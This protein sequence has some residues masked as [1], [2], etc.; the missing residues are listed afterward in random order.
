MDLYSKMSM[1]S[2]GKSGN[3][4]LLDQKIQAL[5]RL[6]NIIKGHHVTNISPL[7][8]FSELHGIVV[9]ITRPDRI[10][11]VEISYQCDYRV[12][13][14]IAEHYG[15]Y[16]TELHRAVENSKSTWSCCLF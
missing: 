11:P 12:I 8:E 7:I 2:I 6:Q 15:L 5:T 1:N 3:D 13:P 4:R 14:Y 9:Q 10:Y 16:T